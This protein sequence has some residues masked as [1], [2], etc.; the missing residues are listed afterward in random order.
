MR[1]HH[2]LVL[3]MIGVLS[4]CSSAVPTTTPGVTLRSRYVVEYDGPQI[5]AE[6]GSRWA[7]THLGD[8][9]LAVK[10]SLSAA[11]GA[12]QKVERNAVRLRTP[13]G[14]ELPIIDKDEFWRIF[15]RLRIRLDVMD[16]WGPPVGRLEG[17]RVPCTEWFLVPPSSF[18]DREYLSLY[19]DQWCSGPL[20]FRPPTGVQAGQWVLIIDLEE[21]SV[22][23]PFI[24]GD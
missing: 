2:L 10:L 18:A 4:A 22:R 8:E 3:V 11:R 23:I 6:L 5:K 1:K 7:S 14:D 9:Y 16:A 17:Y 20:V 15:N 12:V 21:S 19:Q 13:D 24:L